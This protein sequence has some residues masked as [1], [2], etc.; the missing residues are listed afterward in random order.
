MSSATG[1][2]SGGVQEVNWNNLT[3]Q[4][5]AALLQIPTRRIV[6]GLPLPGVPPDGRLSATSQVLFPL[7]SSAGQGSGLS[8]CIGPDGRIWVSDGSGDIYAVTRAGAVS[9]PFATGSGGSNG[10][11]SAAGL[12]WSTSGGGADIYSVSAAGVVTAYTLAGAQAYGI[13]LGQD[14]NLWI[15]DYGGAVWVVPPGDPAGATRYGLTGSLPYGVCAGPDGTLYVS[16]LNK[17]VW[18]VTISGVGTPIAL[19][20]ASVPAII[21]VGG[22]GR[23]WIADNGL[24]QVLA[25]DPAT[26]AVSVYPVPGP[27]F[28][29]CAG[30]DGRIWGG[31][32]LGSGAAEIVAVSADGTTEVF[33]ALGD[34]TNGLCSEADGNLWGGAGVNAVLTIVA[35][36]NGAVT[37]SHGPLSAP[38]VASSPPLSPSRGFPPRESPWPTRPGLIAWSTSPEGRSPRS[39]STDRRR[40]CCPAPSTWPRTRRSR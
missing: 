4:R 19:A 39:P 40:A 20:G 15:A 1:G 35:R 29:M 23:I 9:G 37:A 32:F 10:L 18:S 38:N 3:P 34:G 28:G 33:A 8:L 16:D 36:V 22:D 24:P 5:V 12:V 11:A 21:C 6:S 14:G 25:V 27:F 2:V 7:P 17:Q 13:A 26:H 30:G 31:A